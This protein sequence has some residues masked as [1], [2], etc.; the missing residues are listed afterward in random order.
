MT[1]TTQVVSTEV[2]GI[3]DWTHLCTQHL[4]QEKNAVAL[5][6]P[7]CATCHYLQEYNSF[8][9]IYGS[10]IL[11]HRFISA[12]TFKRVVHFACFVLYGMISFILSFLPHSIWC[13]EFICIAVYYSLH[14]WYRTPLCKYESV[15]WF[16]L[17]MSW[18]VVFSLGLLWVMSSAGI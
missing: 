4:D 2:S 6:K 7:S 15:N 16:I 18:W 14:S 3:R 8:A 12:L 17:L 1:D 10:G 5:Q 13:C 9:W 11:G